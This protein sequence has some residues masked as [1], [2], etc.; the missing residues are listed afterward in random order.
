MELENDGLMKLGPYR[1]RL[2]SMPYKE[3]QK[4]AKRHSLCARGKK[5]ELIERILPFFVKENSVPEE[6]EAM[7]TDQPEK[8]VPQEAVAENNNEQ[9]PEDH[10]VENIRPT[11]ELKTPVPQPKRI[12]RSSRKSRRSSMLREASPMDEILNR[13]ESPVDAVLNRTYSL[14][15]KSSRLQSQEVTGEKGEGDNQLAGGSQHTPKTPTT[16]RKSIGPNRARF[17]MAHSKLHKKMESIDDR[18]KRVQERLKAYQAQTPKRF[19]ELATPKSARAT[20]EIAPPKFDPTIDPKKLSFNF[21]DVSPTRIQSVQREQQPAKSN[22][23]SAKK[24]RP[25]TV[26]KVS[27]RLEELAAP[28]GSTRT[29]VKKPVPATSVSRFTR[30]R[31][32][33]RPYVDT[34]K[35]SNEEFE[36]FTGKKVGTGRAMADHRKNHVEE[37][38]VKRQRAFDK[39]RR[40]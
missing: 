28:K 35:M 30:S 9:V 18:Q 32:A 13:E 10:N 36:R 37:Q 39:N 26:P 5:D 25:L 27:K 6:H 3:L 4:K 20:S 34:T 33:P 19:Q 17:S 29:I 7:E 15:P 22:I 1:V 16:L 21:G 2:S 31:Q 38:K 11:P 40:I 14:S 23:G 24:I 12:S 8:A